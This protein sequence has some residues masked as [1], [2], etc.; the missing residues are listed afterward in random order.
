MNF[1][2][3]CEKRLCILNSL[4]SADNT[5]PLLC[6]VGRSAPGSFLIAGGSSWKEA[7]LEYWG[8]NVGEEKEERGRILKKKRS[9]NGEKWPR[10]IH[11]QGKNVCS[12]KDN[13]YE[14]KS[15]KCHIFNP[16]EKRLSASSE[17]LMSLFL[18]HVTNIKCLP[19]FSFTPNTTFWLPAFLIELMLSFFIKL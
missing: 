2:W 13:K 8:K 19:K 14:K 15:L 18:N 3:G 12:G 6:P 7:Q 1:T 4:N 17:E 11:K 16:A 5:F 9:R 10:V